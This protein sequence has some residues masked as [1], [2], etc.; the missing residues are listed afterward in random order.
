MYNKKEQYYDL[1]A[2]RAL[3]EYRIVSTNDQLSI[4]KHTFIVRKI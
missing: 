3:I 2:G 4:S 1:L